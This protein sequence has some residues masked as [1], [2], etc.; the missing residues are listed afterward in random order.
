MTW[1]TGCLL[2]FVGFTALGWGVIGWEG[3]LLLASIAVAGVLLTLAMALVTPR[4]SMAG[5][6][7]GV[8]HSMVVADNEERVQEA[9]TRLGK[10]PP[11][12]VPTVTVHVHTEPEPVG[13]TGRMDDPIYFKEH[14]PRWFSDFGTQQALV[15]K[16]Q[17]LVD[18]APK[19]NVLPP[20]I[21]LGPAGMGKTLLAK[22]T[23]NE[24]RDRLER[25]G[26]TPGPFL[27]VLGNVDAPDQLDAYLRVA[28]QQPYTTIFFDE[29]HELPR[30]V[31][32]R[33]YELMENGRYRFHGEA[34]P[35]PI[36]VQLMAATTEFGR[37]DPA[38]RRRWVK[39]YFEPATRDELVGVVLSRR[40]I[41]ETAADVVVSRTFFG[42]APWEALELV[43][44]AR[45]A[46][47]S[48]GSTVVD[49]EDIER[50]FAQEQLDT[51]GLRRLDRAVIRALLGQGVMTGNGMVYRAS[52][53][54]LCALAGVDRPTYVEE[55]RPRLQARQLLVVR[56]GQQLTSAAVQ[57]Y[58]WLAA[59]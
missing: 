29:I 31:Y 27:E 25:D 41:T 56:G 3:L 54:A 12:P 9:L 10:V 34:Q 44:L 11:A 28:Q 45:S 22:V 15:D 35:V 50:V 49:V 6:G 20:S 2:A 42:G 14:E 19:G 59:A 18:G 43:R 30:P 47:A 48:R 1:R 13:L 33:L 55:V 4:R 8:V 58:S 36:T 37:M 40:N 5:V 7:M 53:Q 26:Y 51:M 57:A 52:E 21:F 32:T 17:M 23:T 46:A 38:F 16:L 24:F 39:H